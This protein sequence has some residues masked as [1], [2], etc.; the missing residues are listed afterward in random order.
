MDDNLQVQISID[1][2]KF[3]IRVHKDSLRLIGNP[4]YIQLLVNVNELQVAFRG[5]DTDLRGMHAHKVNR[6]A[7]ASDFSF[8]IYSRTF[9][10]M[11][12]TTFDTFDENCTY[13]LTGMA[14]PKDRIA[15]FS[16]CSMQKVED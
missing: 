1:F 13:R 16:I 6:A 10:E 5:V 9:I 14:V 15:V 4:R 8:E 12:R 3:R 2:K 7:L 11:L